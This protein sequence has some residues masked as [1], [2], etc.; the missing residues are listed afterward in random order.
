MG[1]VTILTRF[2]RREE[3]I[4]P[5][6]EPLR[7]TADSLVVH[8]LF[9]DLVGYSKLPM[10]AQLRASAELAQAVRACKT[11]EASE[12]YGAVT[13]MDTGDGMVL[14]FE[15][16]PTAPA[17]L[18]L[19]LAGARGRRP[20]SEIRMGLHSG[21][22]MRVRDINSR[23]NYKG[24]GMNVAQRVMDCAL[25]GQITLSEHHATIL[26]S[27]TGWTERIDTVGTVTVKHGLKLRICEIRH[28][29]APRETL[30]HKLHRELPPLH[31]TIRWLSI[32]A[33]IAF[34]AAGTW[35]LSYQA[36]S[37]TPNYEDVAAS[38]KQVTNAFG[39]GAEE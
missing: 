24:V 29:H 11:F 22:V 9:L 35:S 4:P 33:L 27:Y 17:V 36:F 7:P 6:L 13:C 16:E 19:E 32:L 26:R 1:N 23:T 18:A 12:H 28:D 34:L 25:A 3:S 14:A 37:F 38:S 30:S 31:P 10:E 2:S 8:I 5:A 15:G 20:D 39:T 21:P